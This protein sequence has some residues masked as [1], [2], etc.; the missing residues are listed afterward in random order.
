MPKM[1]HAVLNPGS[2][3]SEARQNSGAPQLRRGEAAGR[4]WEKFPTP[5]LF[6]RKFR[7]ARKFN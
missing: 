7:R 5:L 6:R 1:G 2:N 3:A 4:R